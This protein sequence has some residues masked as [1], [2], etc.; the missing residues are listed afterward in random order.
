MDE[1]SFDIGDF[2]KDKCTGFYGEVIG[3]AIYKYEPRQFYVKRTT[4]DVN[5]L[6][7]LRWFCDSTLESITVK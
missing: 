5:G 7:E 3:I 6:Y 2:V 4:P 1:R